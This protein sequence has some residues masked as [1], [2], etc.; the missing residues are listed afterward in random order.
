MTNDT[1]TAFPDAEVR[2]EGVKYGI[3]LGV[4]MLAIGIVSAYLLMSATNFLKASLISGTLS[5]FVL[6]GLSAYF[7]R[8]LRSA[9]G[10]YWS[11]SQALKGIFAMLAIGA[12]IVQVGTAAFNAIEPE[13]QR[14]VFDKAINSTI[15]TL[16]SAGADDEMIDKQ[17]AELEKQRENLSTFSLGQTLKGLGVTLIMYF[18]FALVLAAVF[19]K[20]RPVLYKT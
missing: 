18:V 17:V 1:N 20:E 16:E 13:P 11:F 12:L 7:S 8:L 9:G 10:G 5:I 4:I 14:V 15:E 3:Y 2:N 6:I 19:K